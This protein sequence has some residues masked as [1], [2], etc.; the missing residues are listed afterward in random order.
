MPGMD[1]FCPAGALLRV[2]QLLTAMSV[3]AVRV[4]VMSFVMAV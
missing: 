2:V 1:W 3:M 4:M